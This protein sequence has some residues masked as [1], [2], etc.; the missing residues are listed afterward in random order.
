MHVMARGLTSWAGSGTLHLGR[1]ATGRASPGSPLGVPLFLAYA[2]HLAQRGV[3]RARASTYGHV[4]GLAQRTLGRIARTSGNFPEAAHHPQA[5]IPPRGDKGA[6]PMGSMPTMDS[7]SMRSGVGFLRR[8]HEDNS[9][10]FWVAAL[11]QATVR[12][13][14]KSPS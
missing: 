12:N 4:V 13:P 14:R 9:G 5:N 2:R 7:N 11:L 3:A 1:H 10:T 8:P 6:R